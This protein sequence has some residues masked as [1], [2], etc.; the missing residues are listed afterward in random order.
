MRLKILASAMALHLLP[1]SS[2]AA[3]TAIDVEA[4]YCLDVLELQDGLARK[5]KPAGADAALGSTRAAR[6]VAR[7]TLEGYLASRRLSPAD[8]ETVKRSRAKP[9]ATDTT[10]LI[11]AS[12]APDCRAG[13]AALCRLEAWMAG[14]ERRRRFARCSADLSWLP[15]V[16]PRD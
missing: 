15:A 5:A 10:D 4:R 6:R 8:A 13:T 9:L 3:P 2:L 12:P 7:R 16:A 14:D 1:T 11:F